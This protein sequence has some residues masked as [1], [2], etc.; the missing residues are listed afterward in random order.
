MTLIDSLLYMLNEM[1]PYILLG[2]L[3]AGLMHAFV[4]QHTMARHLAGRGLRSVLKGAALGVPLPLC[5]C[6]VLP[7]AVALRRGGASR[8]SSASFLIATPQT[9]VDSIAATWSLL[10]PAFAIVRPV[11]ALVTAVAGGVAVGRSEEAAPAGAACDA[12]AA[13]DERPRTFGGRVVAALRYGYIDLVGSIG[14]WL[15]AGLIIAALITVYVPADF[16]AVLGD[17]PLLAMLAVLVVAVPMYV[18]ATGSIPIAMS[19]MLKGLS[20]GT[21]LVLLMAGPAA[22]FASFTL[23]SR[24]MGRKAAAIYLGSIVVGAMAFG[25]AIDYLLPAS[26][27][28]LTG[29]HGAACHGHAETSIFATI[30][31]AILVVLLIVSLIRRFLPHNTITNN[32]MTREYTI[33]GMNCPHCQATVARSISAVKGVN[34]VDVNLSTGKATVEGEH[35]A[36]ELVKAVKA[37]GFD[38]A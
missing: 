15:V 2:F 16:F 28:S 18:C 5:S 20:P 1:S 8:A 3:I 25:L 11:A 17:N 31:S 14:L 4:A 26:W 37:A 29:M 36:E 22:N 23:I 34:N 35:D 32:A 10:G 21:A 12:Q 30:C 38:V 19:L 33:K 6:G 9:G 7:A 13:A 24:E 27:F